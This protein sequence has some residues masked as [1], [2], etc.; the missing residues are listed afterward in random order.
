M[1]ETDLF[2]DALTG[3]PNELLLLDRLSY[4]IAYARRHDTL[5]AV[6]SIVLDLGQAAEVES[7]VI[8]EAADRLRSSMREIDTIARVAPAEFCVVITDVRTRGHAEIAIG[9]IAEVLT[10]PYDI[11]NRSWC[12]VARLGISYYPPH[13]HEAPALLKNAREA[14][15]SGGALTVFGEC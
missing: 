9:K 10:Q 13:G 11:G 7:R 4:A 2:K 1:E 15:A 8:L 6:C 5:L 12:V 14:A 3:L